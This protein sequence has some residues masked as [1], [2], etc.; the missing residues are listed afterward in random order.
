MELGSWSSGTP[1]NLVRYLRGS[2]ARNL[3]NPFHGPVTDNEGV[4]R[5]PAHSDPPPAD[6]IKMRY[7][8]AGVEVVD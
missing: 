2:I 5:I 6:I 7:L 8:V 3:Y 4:I 1:N